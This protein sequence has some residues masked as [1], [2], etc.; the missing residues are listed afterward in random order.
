MM[1]ASVVLLGAV[2]GQ[3][4]P[5]P[6][7]RFAIVIGTNR[8][9]DERSAPLR[10]A[11]D[12]AL[13]V[14]RL[15]EEA[16]VDSRL[17]TVL[18][19]DT[20]K[21]H[22]TVA[23]KAPTA[24]AVRDAFSELVAAMQRAGGPVELLFFYSGHGGVAHG[25]G[26]VAI[27]GGR[28]F[29]STLHRELIAVS[30]AVRN[31]VIVDAC[32]SYFMAYPKGPGGQRQPHGGLLADATVPGRTGFI[33][34]TSSGRDSHEWDRLQSGVFSHQIRSALRGAADVDG[35]GTISYAE[36]GAFLERANVA[37][38]N[39]RFRPDFVVRPPGPHPGDLSQA[40]LTWVEGEDA[41]SMGEEGV[42]RVYLEGPT[43]ERIL[44]IHKR[45]SEIVR[46][47][48]PSVRPLFVRTTDERTEWVIEERGFT[49]LAKLEPRSASVAGK[50]AQHLAFEQ[51]FEAPFGEAD[52]VAFAAD[53]GAGPDP[54]LV[55]RDV[56][57]SDATGWVRPAL[58]I[59]AITLAV[60]GA[61][62][63]T[64]ALERRF[65]GGDLT[66]DDKVARDHQ[67][68][69]LNAAALSLYGGALLTGG[70][71]FGLGLWP[72]N[73]ESAVGLTAGSTF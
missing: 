14:H 3:P 47:Y 15:L 36:I 12:D 5:P 16:G 1:L 71:W 45:P 42:R 65:S 23:P 6:V 59:G 26:Y 73:D 56:S 70:L 28:L 9:D 38:P 22:P 49:K 8:P 62:M 54:L 29:R 57:E 63:T 13:A 32:K 64:W 20:A 44:D 40:V 46:L 51:L 35:D 17:L 24:D 61:V 25:E 10:Y 4:P 69:Q 41:L 19:A 34:S 66:F 52:V 2:A 72:S 60:A 53:Y 39:V 58:G 18:D 67:I 48:L 11:D 43:G 7:S 30:P 31:H 21:L 68:H 55:E 27:E 33:L 50:G 37:I